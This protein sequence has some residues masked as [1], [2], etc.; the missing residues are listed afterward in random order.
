MKNNNKKCIIITSI[1]PK[2]QSLEK[3]A[4]IKKYDLIIVGDKKSPSKYDLNA[5]YLDIKTQNK[6]FPAFSNLLP[7]NHYSRK[8]MGYIYAIANG[9]EVIAESDD[10]NFPYKNW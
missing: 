1:H 4:S 8:N 10:D 5:V 6:L 9:Y 3:F 2:N 7:F